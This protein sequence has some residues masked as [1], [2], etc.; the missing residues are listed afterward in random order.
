M[1]RATAAS[2]QRHAANASVAAPA[3]PMVR[4]FSG[5]TRA[6]NVAFDARTAY[7]FLISAQI[8]LAE[9]SDLLPEDRALAARAVARRSAKPSRVTGRLFRRGAHGHLPRALVD[10][11][12][13]GTIR[14]ASDVVTAVN[15]AGARGI[16]KV[17]IRDGVD[18]AVPDELIERVLDREPAAIAEINPHVN[19]H[20]GGEVNTFLESA[21]QQ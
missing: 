19:E 8:G 10:A 9:E 1:A 16:A 4:D 12:R 15:E 13:P 21:D 7:D 14:S 17:M 11:G 6:Q 18:E 2:T 20:L 5:G 3:R